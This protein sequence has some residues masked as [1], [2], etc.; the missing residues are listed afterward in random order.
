MTIPYE[1]L[2]RTYRER[3][4]NIQR[5]FPIDNCRKIAVHCT[6]GYTLFPC[7]RPKNYAHKNTA[8]GTISRAAPSLPLSIPTHSPA[9]H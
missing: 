6:D 5:T 2:Q 3:I 9:I 7:N 4:E 1:D 8:S